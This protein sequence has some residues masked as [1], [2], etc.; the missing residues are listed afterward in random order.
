MQG[1]HFLHIP[2][3]S[4]I[5]DR[6]L[7]AIAM[8]IIDHRS[9]EFAAL[10]KEVLEGGMD[11]MSGHADLGQGGSNMGGQVQLPRRGL[12]GGAGGGGTAGA[13]V[14]PQRP[15]GPTPARGDIPPDASPPP[16]PAGDQ[17]GGA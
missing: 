4:P 15:E 1:R 16:P 13:P 5:P 10:G 8:P 2:G 3:P 17:G 6:I 9:A 11:A 12:G 14:P 7:R